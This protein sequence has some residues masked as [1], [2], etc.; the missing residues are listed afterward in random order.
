VALQQQ[1]LLRGRKRMVV[2]DIA[3]TLLQTDALRA[4]AAAAGQTAAM[5][6]ALSGDAEADEAAQLARCYSLLKVCDA[7]NYIPIYS[8]VL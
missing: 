3:G 1:S 2:F 8:Y 4:L 7:C 6:K 5:E